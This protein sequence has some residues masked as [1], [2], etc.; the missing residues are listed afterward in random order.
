M[1]NPITPAML[2]ELDAL[3]ASATARP[4]PFCGNPYVEVSENRLLFTTLYYCSCNECYAHGKSIGNIEAAIA[5][6]NTRPTEAA[7][8]AANARLT[9][10]NDKARKE[11]QR[12]YDVVASMLNQLHDHGF[13]YDPMYAA[14][15]AAKE[16]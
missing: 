11:V 14:L 4:C 10:E 6:W 12:L 7:L 1:P 3:A 2:D 13:E 5:A 15:A 8:S 9:A 16:G